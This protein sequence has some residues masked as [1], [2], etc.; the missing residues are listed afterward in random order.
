MKTVQT[1]VGLALVT[2]LPL[3][4]ME[5]L[6]FL[7]DIAAQTRFLIAVPL[8]VLAEIPIGQR[9]NELTRYFHDAGLVRMPDE[10]KFEAAAAQVRRLNDYWLTNLIVLIVTYVTVLAWPSEGGFYYRFVAMPVFYFLVYRWIFRILV[11]T[12]GLWRI[13]R[14]DLFLM[15]AHPD[16]AG[17][18]NLVGKGLIPFGYILFALS[19][20]VA[21]AIA[22]RVRYGGASLDQFISNYA[23]MILLGLIVLVLPVLVFV[24]KLIRLKH[25]GLEK[26]GTLASTYSHQF[27][28][29]WV[30]GITGEALM[31]SADIQSLADLGSVCESVRRMRIVPM[32]LKDFAAIVLLG[33]IPALPLAALVM[34][35]KEILKGIVR[36]LG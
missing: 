36:L 32:E 25:E 5:G 9:W 27:D 21:G 6:P 29:K 4:V 10:E 28:R 12:R 8:L 26:Y 13:S 30:G 18:L 17:G 19:A 14:L 3:L 31:G 15:P 16:G 1:A 20:V 22:T 7:K 35:V 11:W 33:V 23:A 34:P 2:W 24:P